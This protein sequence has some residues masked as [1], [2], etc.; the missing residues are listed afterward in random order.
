MISQDYR[1]S[2]TLH[3]PWHFLDHF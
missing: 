3:I 2:L 1:K